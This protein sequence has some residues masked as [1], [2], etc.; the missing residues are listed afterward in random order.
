MSVADLFATQTAF[1]QRGLYQDT[2]ESNQAWKTAFD[3]ANNFGNTA[4]T[5]RKHDEN[6]ATS[7]Y[8]VG[9]MN[10]QN[11]QQIDLAP[12][13]TQAGIAKAQYETQTL[14]ARAAYDISRYGDWTV[15]ENA[16][17]EAQAAQ[18]GWNTINA[19]IQSAN[20]QA[21]FD[22]ANWIGAYGFDPT[23]GQAKTDTELI[24]LAQEQ[25]LNPLMIAQLFKPEQPQKINQSNQVDLRYKQQEFNKAYQNA[26]ETDEDGIAYLNPE[27][28][29]TEIARL[30]A[31]YGANDPHL[32]EFSQRIL[33]EQG[34]N[35]PS[36]NLNEPNAV[37]TG[38]IPM[39]AGTGQ[40]GKTA[41][42]V[43]NEMAATQVKPVTLTPEQKRA[44]LI[45][46]LNRHQER[47]MLEQSPEY[48]KQQNLF[49]QNAIKERMEHSNRYTLPYYL[50]YR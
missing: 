24:Q 27:K 42:Q 11:K 40:S 34:W 33:Q 21:G 14:P 39:P 45:E 49:R 50:Q 18:Y 3:I 38:G 10:A 19:N 2:P 5:L 12:W 29:K 22:L 16:R 36:S 48:I 13:Q 30:S 37:P 20:A 31:I 28:L 8:R 7:A 26:M 15:N 41:Q 4:E 23:T 46:S 35:V 43:A 17:R 44:E 25:G 9:A 1:N 32:T 6:M 47:V